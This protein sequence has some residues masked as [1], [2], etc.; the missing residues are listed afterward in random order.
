MQIWAEDVDNPGT[1]RAV[2]GM[3][4]ANGYFVLCTSGT[5]SSTPIDREDFLYMDGTTFEFMDATTFEY[6]NTI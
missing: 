1:L 5:G 4:D 3:Y 6:M 2:Q